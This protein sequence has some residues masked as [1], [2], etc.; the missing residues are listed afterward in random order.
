[1]Q[2]FSKF[3]HLQ[4][5]LSKTLFL[6]SLIFTLVPSSTHAFVDVLPSHAILTGLPSLNPLD[7][8]RFIFNDFPDLADALLAPMI[9]DSSDRSLIVDTNSSTAD[10]V[11]KLKPKFD[12]V[13]TK[14]G[15]VLLGKMPGMRKEDLSLEIVDGPNG[16]V[17]EIVGVAANRSCD[18][19]SSSDAAVDCRQ[20]PACQSS[21]PRV[22]YGAFKRRIHLSPS[23]DPST[24]QARFQDGL[25]VASM[26]ASTKA[27]RH[28]VEIL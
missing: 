4:P 26:L 27:E 20:T 22:A 21:H 11:I 5:K 10:P 12:V 16:R 15:V 3:H 6:A 24:L 17:L 19:L 1:M 14:K 28:K 8:F 13:K 18:Q 25:L 9:D 7:N 2:I 23:L